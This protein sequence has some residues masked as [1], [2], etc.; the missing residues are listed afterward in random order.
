MDTLLGPVDWNQAVRQLLDSGAVHLKRALDDRVLAELLAA[1]KIPWQTLPEHEGV[2]RQIGSGAYQTL[3]KSDHVV[4]NLAI[5]ITNEIGRQT[6][7]DV[8]TPPEFNEVSWSHYPSGRGHITAHRDPDAYVGLIAVVTLAGSATF[9]VW[10]GGVLGHP[11][12]VIVG[13]H[14]PSDW[15]AEAGDVV[16]S[17]GNCWPSSTDRCPVHEALA[18]TS[19]E[20]VIMTLRSNSNGAGGGYEVS[21]THA[22]RKFGKSGGLGTASR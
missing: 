12:A 22:G 20:R 5:E 8:S 1:R 4:P 3:E 10:D 17:R 19:G 18:P 15:A 14:A 16:V 13:S 6:T 21:P 7:A 2:V 9:R 11:T